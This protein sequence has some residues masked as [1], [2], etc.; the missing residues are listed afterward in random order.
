MKLRFVQALALTGALALAGCNSTVVT[1]DTL[2][3]GDGGYELIPRSGEATLQARTLK[4]DA[5]DNFENAVISFKYATTT[6]DSEV[7][8]NWDL[9]FGNDVDSGS[10]I[11]SVNMVTDDR[12]WIVDLGTIPIEAVPATLDPAAYPAGVRGKHDDV[13]V[14][15]DHVYYVRNLDTDTEQVAVFRVGAYTTDTSVIIQWFRSTAEDSFVFP[16]GGGTK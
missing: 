11:F 10:D 14:V 12:S 1:G 16:V 9:L 2:R 6:E 3:A 7:A 8:N 15:Q 5:G 13:P 4:G